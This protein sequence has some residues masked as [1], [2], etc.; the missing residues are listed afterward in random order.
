MSMDETPPEGGRG[1]FGS[2]LATHW[3]TFKGKIPRQLK[4]PLVAVR[5]APLGGRASARNPQ[6]RRLRRLAQP[7]R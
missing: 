4:S 2:R 1:T 5:Q 3:E 6:A 7:H